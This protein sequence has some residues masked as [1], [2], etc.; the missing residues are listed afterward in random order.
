[1]KTGI[2]RVIGSIAVAMLV[3]GGREALAQ[4]FKYRVEHDHLLGSCNGDL[5]INR[6]GVEYRTE[7]Q[8]HSRKWAYTDIEMM[9]LISPRKLEILTY[10]SALMKLGSDRAF[11]FN[12]RE[13]DMTKDVSEFLLKR[14]GR[15]LSTTFV[16]SEETPRYAIPVR[17]R[18]SFGGCQG[19]LKVYADR[20]VYESQKKQEN[21]RYWRWTDIQGVSRT[22]PYQLSIT[23]FEPKAG[24][25]TKAFDFDLKQEVTDP[26]Y[27]YLWARVYRPTLPLSPEGKRGGSN[28]QHQ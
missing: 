25:P 28:I 14:V 18:H 12:L 2:I 8:R 26:M 17:H 16:A 6:D 9:K 24:G 13:D 7:N 23:T 15:P 5:F 11:E 10:E 20:V 1:M 19:T 22:S 21:S 4:E 3:F 27:D